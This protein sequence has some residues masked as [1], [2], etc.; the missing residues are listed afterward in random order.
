MY[1][2]RLTTTVCPGEKRALIFLENITK[3]IR[4]EIHTLKKII[5]S[6][7]IQ[8]ENHGQSTIYSLKI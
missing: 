2:L 5:S 3:I 1:K 8:L 7:F 4:P 6:S